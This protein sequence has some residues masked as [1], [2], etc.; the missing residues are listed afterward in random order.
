MIKKYLKC[1]P[2]WYLLELYK[3]IKYDLDT[4]YKQ[5]ELKNLINEFSSY[6]EFQI[7]LAIA[8]EIIDRKLT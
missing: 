8:I 1:Q 7:Y 6:N 4:G 3:Q 5:D 2:N